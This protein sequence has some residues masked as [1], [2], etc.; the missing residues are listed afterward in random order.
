[1]RV[2]EFD[3]VGILTPD[4]DSVRHLFGDLLGLEVRGPEPEP[5]LGAE[6]LWVFAGGVRLEF[7]R[8][9]DPDSRVARAL[10][11]G[12]VGVHHVAF[13]VDDAAAALS[14]L[15]AAGVPLRDAS[16]RRG[17]HGTRIGFVDPAAGG[18]ALVEVVSE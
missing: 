3:H 15:A 18:G 9:T 2:R 4:L 11:A 16:P 6:V 13:R 10:A 12:Q 7:I 5:E 1:M 17:V 14:E 8:P